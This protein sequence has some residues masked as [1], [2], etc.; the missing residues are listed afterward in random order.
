MTKYRCTRCDVYDPC[1]YDSG[2]AGSEPIRCPLV[3]G[4][5]PHWKPIRNADYGKPM[6]PDWIKV[7][8]LVYFWDDAV[9]AEITKIETIG[10]SAPIIH[11][12]NGT[13]RICGSLS[14][15]A[16]LRARLRPYNAAEMK[17]LVG[18]VL[19][20]EENRDLVISYDGERG[21]VY[22]DDMWLSGEDL[23]NNGYKYQESPCGVLEYL[24]KE[25]GE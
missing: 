23:L 14:W 11:F 9:Y 12:N 1:F 3:E 10:C 6:I 22:V 5:K 8:A 25:E 20:W 24:H 2:K 18:K 15:D 7:G 17:A 16:V 13:S 19:D 21:E 4:I